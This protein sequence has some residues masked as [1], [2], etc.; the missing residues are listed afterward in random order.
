MA[1]ASQAVTSFTNKYKKHKP[2]GFCYHVCFDDK[3]YS[4][5]PVIYR[6]KSEDED[7]AQIFV[8]VLEETSNALPIMRRS[9][10]ASVNMSSL[11]LSSAKKVKKLTLRTSFAL[12]TTS[13]SWLLPSIV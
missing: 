2:C 8:E 4:Q 1:Y 5:E 7:V 9:T 10:S 6:A 12:S 3:L 13:I 11:A